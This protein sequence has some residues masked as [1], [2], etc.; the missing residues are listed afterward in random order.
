[1]EGRRSFRRGTEPCPPGEAAP[2][3][4]E[5]PA[6]RRADQ[7]PRRGHPPCP[8]RG[9]ARV[10]GLR[11][12]HLPRP[13]VPGPCRHAYPRLRRQLGGRL[14]RGQPRGLRGRPPPTARRRGRPTPPHHLQEAHPGLIPRPLRRVAWLA[15]QVSKNRTSPLSMSWIP[16]VV[17]SRP[18]ILVKI[19]SAC[20][21]SFRYLATRR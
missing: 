7:R 9:A 8:G 11:G 5:P 3:G 6:A 15:G 2:L 14:V 21:E 1:A 16:M 18:P 12:R 13:V 17:I 4:R 19:P 10:R 20:S